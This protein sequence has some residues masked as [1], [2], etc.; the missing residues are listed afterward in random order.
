MRIA[1]A[2]LQ[3]GDDISENLKKSLRCIESAAE[4]GAE[5]IFFPELQLTPFFP[6]KSGCSAKRYLMDISCA[7]IGE[8]RG[9]CRRNHIAASPNIYLS[10]NG[11]SYDASLMIDS[12][13]DILGVS[14]MVHTASFP[15]FYEAEYYTPSD[16]GFEVYDIPVD[17]GL[18]RVG[19]VICFDRHFPESIRSCALKGADIVI[20]PT[21][22]IVGEPDEMFLWE[23]RVQAMQNSVFVAMCNRVGRSGE[24]MFSGKSAVVDCTGAVVEY[25][26]SDERL[27]VCGID[28]KQAAL[29]RKTMPYFSSRRPDKYIK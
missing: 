11:K 2:Q 17:G 8:I 24:T 23:L 19:I 16:S 1:L 25:A 22:N 28:Y 15:G 18:C 5:L 14:K 12:S 13:G 3:I 21:A 9:A 26:G 20:I 27:I 6:Q 7:E 10:E 4:Q 29:C